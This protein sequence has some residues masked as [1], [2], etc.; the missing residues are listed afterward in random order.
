MLQTALMRTRLEVRDARLCDRVLSLEFFP[1]RASQAVR[2]GR[3]PPRADPLWGKRR[4][5]DNRIVKPRIK[6]TGS[7]DGTCTPPTDSRTTHAPR[8]NPGTLPVE[9]ARVSRHV[10][11]RGGL[12]HR[13]P[14]RWYRSRRGSRQRHSKVRWRS[15]DVQRLCDLCHC[16]RV[17]RTGD[18]G[19]QP[20]TK[21]CQ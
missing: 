15:R 17:V 12:R 5:V 11:S 14:D 4:G 1:N 13:L 16:G 9:G 6:I 8:P 10:A 3:D 20:R 7:G 19:T 21:T 2:G 18:R